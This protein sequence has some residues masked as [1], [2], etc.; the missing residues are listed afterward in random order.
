MTVRHLIL[1]EILYRKVNFLLAVIAVLLAT[2]CG[3]AELTLLRAHDLRTE[4]LLAER[5]T[6]T[7]ERLRQLEDDYRKIGVNMGFNLLI[8]PKEQN[9]GDLYADDYATKY[10]PEE[11]AHKLAAAR[12]ATINHLLPSLQQRVKWPEYGRTIVVMGVRGEVL[13]QSS[14]QKP[15]LEAVPAG[16]LVVGHELA[17]GLGLKIGQGVKLLGRPFTIGKIHPERGNKDDITVWMNLLEAQELLDKK[18]LINAMLALECNCAADRLGKIREEIG[19]VLPD[20]QV[21]EFATQA[22]ARAEARNRA[23]AEAITAV[24]QE[25]SQRANLRT[26]RETLAAWLIPLALLGGATGVGYLAWSNVRQRAGEI[27]ILRALGVRSSRILGLVLGK[28]LIVGCA[29][30]FPGYCLGLTLASL[31]NEGLSTRE[32]LEPRLL[33]A[34][35]IGA[36]LL[37]LAATWLPA[38]LASQQDP[39]LVLREE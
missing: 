26:E 20:T 22:V 15:I 12:V 14:K 19:S 27:G 2:A 30:A 3:V 18:G 10:M 21:V 8:L 13:I 7:G 38:L 24:E 1:R 25:R 35:L 33:A 36:L 39:A 34:V 23:A 28:A 4:I 9:L 31:S 17:Q 16:T 32:I 6:Q 37:S 5:E 29:G 11:Y